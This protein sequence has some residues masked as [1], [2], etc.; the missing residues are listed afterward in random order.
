MSAVTAFPDNYITSTAIRC[1]SQ[2]A[3]SV[4]RRVNSGMPYPN[5]MNLGCPPFKF[6]HQTFSNTNA[7]YI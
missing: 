3:S 1:Y 5:K 7:A 2:L 6:S 4:A